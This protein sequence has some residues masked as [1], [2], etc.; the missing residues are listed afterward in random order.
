MLACNVILENLVDA[1]KYTL[2]VS[3]VVALSSGDPEMLKAAQDDLNSIQETNHVISE[4]LFMES[5]EKGIIAGFDDVFD[6]NLEK[7]P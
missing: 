5:L 6:D 1:T 3:Q 2:S 4:D 7:R